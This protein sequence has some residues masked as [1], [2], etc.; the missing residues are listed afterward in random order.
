MSGNPDRDR[1][2]PKPF[3]IEKDGDGAFR[4]TLRTG[5]YNSQNYPIV[6]STL[7]DEKFNTAAA[8]RTF[9]R[10]N[11]AAGTGEFAVPRRSAK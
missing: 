11:F 3:L 8:A 7:V 9:A 1:A 4:L 6:T 5:R 10:T 2:F